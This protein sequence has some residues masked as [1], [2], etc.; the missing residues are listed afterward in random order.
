IV[1]AAIVYLAIGIIPY[2]NFYLYLFVFKML[3]LVIPNIIK[4]IRMH[5]LLGLEVR[6]FFLNE[7]YILELEGKFRSSRARFYQS[8]Q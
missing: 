4:K 1:L 5:N 3:F 8:P 7:F 2:I 6:V